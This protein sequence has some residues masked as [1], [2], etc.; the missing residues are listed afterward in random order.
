MRKWGIIAAF[1]GCLALIGA[2]Y[3]YYRRHQAPRAGSSPRDALVLAWLNAPAEHPGWAA[4]AGAV[5]GSAPFRLPTGGLIGYLWGDTFEAGHPHQGI[6]IFGGAQPGETAVYA[7]YDGYLT[8]KPDWKSTVAIRIPSD[9][10]HPGRQIWTYYTHLAGVSGASFVDPAFPPGTNEV[11]V[12]AGT[13]LG[14]QG[15]YSGDP[16]SPVGVHLH[17]SI[18]LDDGQGSLRN[19]L[20][21]QNT[22]D[23][24]AYFGLGL[25][26]KTAGATPV[27]CR[28]G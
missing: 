18:V 17:F 20:L 5:C 2:G 16:A 9:P 8:R 11:F 21:I 26:A 28:E 19:E 6:D 14:R 4:K 13:L 25:D 1:V 10:L 24:S 15:N 12:P 22:L 27:T 3:L 23:P 7:A